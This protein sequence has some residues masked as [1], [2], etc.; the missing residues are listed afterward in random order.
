MPGFRKTLER[1]FRRR[2]VVKD[3][4]DAVVASGTSAQ[5]DDEILGAQAAIAPAAGTI[6]IM[7]AGVA[8]FLN[9]YATQPLLPMFA[10]LFA[11]SKAAVGMT[12][13][14][15]TI[16]VA[17]SAPFCGLIAER[18]GRKRVIVLSTLLLAVPTLLASA[19]TSLPMLIFW[20]FFQGM[21]MPGIFGVAIAYIAEEWTPGTVARTMS[22]YVSATVLGGFLGR[23]IIGYA[24]T[25]RLIPSI[26][27]NWRLGFVIIGACD[28]LFGLAIARWLP[29]DRKPALTPIQNSSGVLRHLRNP[30]LLA[31]YAVGFNVLFS[32]VAV[33]TYITFHL[34]APPY[35]LTPA[36]LSSLF[37]V[38]LAGLIVTPLAGIGIGRFGS[39]PVLITAVTASMTGVSMT[40]FHSMPLILAGL[41]LCSSG[42][43]VCQSASTSYIQ[44]AAAAGGRA[45]AA[46]LYVAFYYTGGSVAGVLPGYF[47]RFGGWTA[48]V[49]LVLGVQLVTITIAA[50][51][52]RD[53]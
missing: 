1:A 25:H 22:L 52:W 12:V 46:G 34:A 38:Y 11:A 5:A 36:Q 26:A 49:A 10:Q 7:L 44:T 41:V 21:V 18:V 30:R 35:L 39:R 45:S 4:A 33:F 17:L 16:G 3:T 47:W 43:F 31:T 19:T 15:A 27:P 2:V 28:L 40:L 37:V 42:V 50:I 53:S 29:R 51:G 24:A 48:C 8:A 14:A 6:A 9:L 32:L 13:S 23:V 20:R